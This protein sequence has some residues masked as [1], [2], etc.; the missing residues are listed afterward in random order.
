MKQFLA[1]A[2]SILIGISAAIAGEPPADMQVERVEFEIHCFE[3]LSRMVEVLAD[4]FGE[5]PVVMSELGSNTHFVLFSNEAHTTSTLVI[6]KTS[7][8]RGDACIIWSGSSPGLSFAI[9]S[10]PEYPEPKQ[11]GTDL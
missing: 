4:H 1:I 5:V 11:R 3:G 7:E 6:H 2:T 10:N 9:A 8:D